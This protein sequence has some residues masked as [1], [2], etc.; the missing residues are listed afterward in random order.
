VA[1]IVYDVAVRF[2]ERYVDRFSR[3]KDLIGQAA[4]SGVHNIAEGSQASTTSVTARLV[5]A[6]M[7]PLAAGCSGG[8]SG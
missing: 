8:R 5:F 4:R 7:A 3:T 2:C 1:Q 6:I